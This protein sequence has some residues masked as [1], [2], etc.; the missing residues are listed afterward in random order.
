MSSGNWFWGTA[1]TVSH[2]AA[3]SQKTKP[4]ATSVCSD[5]P[6]ASPAVRKVHLFHCS[7][8]IVRT[9]LF[10]GHIVGKIMREPS[11]AELWLQ[12]AGDRDLVPYTSGPPALLGAV[13]EHR[14]GRVASEHCQVRL[15]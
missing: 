9:V 11:R 13:S 15:P 4:A 7:G 5:F 8:V 10:R 12:H 1:K 14:A 3:V 2:V 6:V